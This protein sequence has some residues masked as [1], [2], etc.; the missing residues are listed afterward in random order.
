LKAIDV[1]ISPPRIELDIC[2][3]KA[4][5]RRNTMFYGAIT[6]GVSF[7]PDKDIPDVDG[8]VIFVTGGMSAAPNSF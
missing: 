1:A 3:R 8:K 2:Q 5:S 6:S 7:N 4:G